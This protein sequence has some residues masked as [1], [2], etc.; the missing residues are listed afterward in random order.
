MAAAIVDLTDF[1]GWRLVTFEKL[2]IRLIE[3]IGQDL[4]DRIIPH[5]REMFQ[6][7]RKREELTK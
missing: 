7:G 6:R 3:R 5:F 4:G 2:R 1:P